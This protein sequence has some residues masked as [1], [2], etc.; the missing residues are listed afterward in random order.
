ML[1]AQLS[2]VVFFIMAFQDV[3]HRYFMQLGFSALEIVMYGLVPTLLFGALYIWVKQIPLTKP[4]WKHLALFVFSGVL[5]FFTFLWMR[6]AQILSPNI[7]YVSVIIYSSV[8]LTILL[9]AYLF[10]DHINA[11]GVL[12]SV[13]IVAGL[14]L[15]T[16][17]NHKSIK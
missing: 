9:T 16:S 5:S 2:F 11:R 13:L 6:R 15:V 14:G 12:G 3:L 4:S 10:G 7:G 1:W 8:I 17:S